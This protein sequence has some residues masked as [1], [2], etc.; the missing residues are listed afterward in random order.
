MSGATGRLFTEFAWA[1][2]GAVLVSGFVALTLSPM[3]CARFLLPHDRERHNAVSRVVENFLNGLT[4]GYRSLLGWSFKAR[5][6][7]LIIGLLVAAASYPLFTG[8][9]SE[10][11]P[12]EDQGL[13]RLFYM[14]P[15]GSTIEYTDKYAYRFEALVENIPEVKHFFAVSG[16]PV[17]S[18]GLVFLNMKPWGERSRSVQQIAR[19]IAPKAGANPGLR[20]FP[21]LP[22]PLGQSRNAKPVEVIIQTVEPYEKLDEW[23]SKITEKLEGN[24]GLANLDSDLKLNSPQLKITVARDKMQSLGIDVATLGRTLETLF[25]GRQVTRFKR[26]GEQYDVIVQVADIERTN[27]DD[28]RRVY[29]RSTS[30]AMVQLSNV[31]SISET[32]APKELNHFNK[33]RAAKISA[34]LVGDYSLAEGLA[35]VEAV[36]REVLPPS[37]RIDY[38]GPSREF[39]QA[40]NDIYIIFGLALA[41]IYLVLSAQFESFRD[42]FIIMFTV[43]LSVTGAL[44]ALWL[45]GGTLNIYSQVGLVTLIGLITK[46]GILIVEFAN[47]IHAKGEDLYDAVIEAS[48]LRLR[49]ILMTTGAMVLGA[50]PLAI[51]VGAGAESRQDIGWVIVGG[52]LV[53]TFFTLFVIPVVY[54]YLARR[55]HV[56]AA[57]KQIDGD[58][59][60]ADAA[61]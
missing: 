15:E 55:R 28:L 32:V 11:A 33:L 39:K 17:V 60:L 24:S 40:S 45:S 48:A 5:P 3:M 19:E 50:V 20:A 12:Y 43:P 61:E 31:V 59:G 13:V 21:I 49:P 4:S 38:S 14:A 53:G 26:N 29:V 56:V 18:Q 30:G 27:P 10:L 58:I 46:H 8:L 51:A 2:A 34:N 9:K 44:L 25:G 22:P 36:A 52:L 35:A 42:P 7:V 16:F 54:T 6:V 41:F 1:L 37:A 57:E 47:Q 23:V